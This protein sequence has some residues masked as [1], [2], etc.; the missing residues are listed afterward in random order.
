M[1][2]SSSTPTLRGA[3]LALIDDALGELHTGCP[4]RVESYDATKQRCS[5]QPL[6]RRVYEDETGARQSE[7][8]PVI[9]DVPVCFPGAGEW[10]ITFP[11]ARGDTVWLEFA[12]AS[13]DLWLQRGGEV[14]PEDP[15]KNALSDAVAYPGVRDFAHALPG[16]SATSMVIGNGTIQ[17]EVTGSAINAGGGLTIALGS[18]VA[19]LKSVLAS[20][21]PFAGDGGLALKTALEAAFGGVGLPGWDP[22]TTVLKGS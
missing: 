2:R 13:L 22:E 4:A 11:L 15:R 18:G 5:V 9:T 21:V 6:I 12:S 17:I 8:H 19:T 1:T 16:V 3:A 20:W 14:D 10:R 7:R